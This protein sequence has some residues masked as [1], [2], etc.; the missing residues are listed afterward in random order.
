M[1]GGLDIT[2]GKGIYVHAPEIETKADEKVTVEAM[3]VELPSTLELNADKALCKV[4]N[5]KAD[6]AVSAPAISIG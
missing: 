1:G 3:T 4:M 5:L 2:S 6:V